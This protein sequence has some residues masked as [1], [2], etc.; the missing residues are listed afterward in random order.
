MYYSTAL[1]TSAVNLTSISSTDLSATLTLRIQPPNDDQGLQTLSKRL[2]VWTPQTI[3]RMEPVYYDIQRQRSGVKL[4]M[5]A[6]ILND[7]LSLEVQCQITQER[8][9]LL[10]T[11]TLE[12]FED[13]H[14]HKFIFYPNTD[15][16]GHKTITRLLNYHQLSRQ[17]ENQTNFLLKQ[18][19]FD[20]ITENQPGKKEQP[21]RSQLKQFSST[22]NKVRCSKQ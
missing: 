5:K 12:I 14:H 15:T 19:L 10:K 2:R 9:Q 20:E 6:A 4:V 16:T 22:E 11:I 13:L 3:L 18:T 8:L 21:L 7:D 1:R 17:L